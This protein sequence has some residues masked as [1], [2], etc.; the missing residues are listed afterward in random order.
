MKTTDEIIEEL[1][2]TEHRTLG[3]VKVIPI[4]DLRTILEEKDKECE[5]R[6]R[7]ERERCIE[8]AWEYCVKAT[9]EES[10]AIEELVLALAPTISSDK[11]E[12]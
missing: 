7:E 4:E 11:T 12:V 10:G 2:V 5:E 1:G 9:R 8:K 6:V 3:F